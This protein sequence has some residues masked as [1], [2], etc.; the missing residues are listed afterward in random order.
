MKSTFVPFV[1]RPEETTVIF[2]TTLISWPLLVEKGLTVYCE[3]I[4][5]LL[6]ICLM[7][8]LL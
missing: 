5:K 3:V 1:Q 8:F 2:C 7:K 4:T 6:S